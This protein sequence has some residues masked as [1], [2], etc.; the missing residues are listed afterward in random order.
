ME[1]RNE[2][3]FEACQKLGYFHVILED[4]SFWVHDG[5]NCQRYL[6]SRLNDGHYGSAMFIVQAIQVLSK[7]QS[8]TLRILEKGTYTVEIKKD[9]ALIQVFGITMV[10]ALSRA[11]VSV[12]F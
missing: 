12:A 2:Q 4:D 5:S 10:E 9:N 3:L 8:F 6:V 7:F 1:S 11:V